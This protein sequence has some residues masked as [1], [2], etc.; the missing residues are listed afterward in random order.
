MGKSDMIYDRP[1]E[2]VQ[3]QFFGVY[4]FFLQLQGSLDIR[5]SGVSIQYATR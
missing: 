4:V 1:C 3:E 2:T 5:H